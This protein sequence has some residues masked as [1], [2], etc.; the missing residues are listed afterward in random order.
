MCTHAA[1]S[2][3]KEPMDIDNQRPTNSLI[4]SIRAKFTK[5]CHGA[6]AIPDFAMMLCDTE[7]IRQYLDGEQKRGYLKGYT[8][9]IPDLDT[10]FY[11]ILYKRHDCR[12]TP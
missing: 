1:G 12:C 9:L 3:L 7:I 10:N 2:F 11:S 4:K 6:V 5:Q 8:I